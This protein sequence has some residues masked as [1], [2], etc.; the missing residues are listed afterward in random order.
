M[1]DAC[2]TSTA[3]RA[4]DDEVQLAVMAAQD[5]TAARLATGLGD[6]EGLDEAAGDW[7]ADTVEVAL[8]P[9]DGVGL[10]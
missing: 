2:M 5:G 6:D 9:G 4:V 10:G 3:S 8:A 7:L 1:V